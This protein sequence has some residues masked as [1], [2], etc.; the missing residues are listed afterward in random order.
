M[1]QPDVGETRVFTPA[2]Y[3]TG[4][5]GAFQLDPEFLTDPE[6]VL[7]LIGTW[8]LDALDA[9]SVLFREE[10]ER[11]EKAELVEVLRAIAVRIPG[12]PVVAVK[13]ATN[14]NYEEGVYWADTTLWLHHQDGAET[15]YLLP[16]EVGPTEDFEAL[17]ERFRDLLADYSRADHPLDGA[18]LVFEVESGTFTVT[19]PPLD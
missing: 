6:R 4:G 10:L 13:L 17:V 14:P 2:T 8:T 3:A 5:R 7:P 11:R 15:E 16:D 9:V 1:T 12:L 18:S 19:P